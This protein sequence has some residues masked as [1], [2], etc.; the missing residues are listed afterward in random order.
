MLPLNP[1]SFR[2]CA[3]RPVRVVARAMGMP[4]EISAHHHPWGQA[5][6]SDAGVVQV[7]M[8]NVAFIVPPQ[9][10]V[11]IPPGTEH[12]AVLLQ[13]ASLF[14]VYVFLQESGQEARQRFW[15]RCRVVRA[16]PLLLELVRRLVDEDLPHRDTGRY[17][18][19]CVVVLAELQDAREVGIGVPMPTERRLRMLCEAFLAEPRQSKP[20]AQLARDAGASVSTAS[21]LFRDELGMGFQQWRRQALFA[22]ALALAAEGM[23]M[24]RIAEELGYS[25][26]S[27][28]TAMVTKTFGKSPRE[29]LLQRP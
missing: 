21:R 17:R 23:P 25:S 14:S 9:H 16:S 22:R 29:F 8:A 19:L 24:Q 12:S 6:F 10:A 26:A 2:P 5:V 18:A 11:L 1:E 20:L 7:E 13:D 28:F 15:D 27:A 4:T 3:E